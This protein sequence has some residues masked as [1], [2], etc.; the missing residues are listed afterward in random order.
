MQLHDFSAD[1]LQIF[2]VD[3]AC[4][5]T[6]LQQSKSKRFSAGI[7]PFRGVLSIFADGLHLDEFA[8]GK[9]FLSFADI[10]ASRLCGIQRPEEYRC[11]S[12]KTKGL[13][14]CNDFVL[15]LVKM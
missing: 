12:N 4:S 15:V 14:F 2:F 3:N 5:F 10:A 1:K 9:V 6:T 13:N 7:A 11:N 8:A